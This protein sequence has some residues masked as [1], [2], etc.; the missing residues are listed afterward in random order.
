M[1]VITQLLTVT[2]QLQQ[3]LASKFLGKIQN[4]Q[5]QFYELWPLHLSLCSG[6]AITGFTVE[7]KATFKIE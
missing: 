6:N 3:A 4:P 5:K 7:V 2:A 1:S